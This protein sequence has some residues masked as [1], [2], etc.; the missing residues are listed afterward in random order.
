MRFV[1]CLVS[2]YGAFLASK[3][4]EAAWA[5]TFGVIALL[6]NPFVPI[7]LDRSTWALLDIAAGAI[8]VAS[9]MNRRLVRRE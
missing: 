9:L 1:V 7:H 2:A 6:F 4:R 8:I 5:W 3:Q